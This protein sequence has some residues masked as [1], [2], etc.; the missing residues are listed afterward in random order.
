MLSNLAKTSDVPVFAVAG[1]GYRSAIH[2]L[3]VADGINIVASPRHA[4]V[5]LIAGEFTDSATE[6][7]RRVH[8]QMA[9]PR[10]TVSWGSTPTS[11]VPTATHVDGDVSTVATVIKKQFSDV[12]TGVIPAE[13]PVLGNV[14]PV[15]WRGVGPYGHGGAGMTGG[16]PYGRP[17]A[18]RA[19]S[20]DALEL[21]QLPVVIGPWF[22]G[23][24]PGLSLR[25]SLQGDVAQT[26][27]V[28]PTNPIGRPSNDIFDQALY[29]PV[30][31]RELEMARARHLIEWMADTFAIA[32]VDRLAVRAD[33]LAASISPG[34]SRP[35]ERLKAAARRA[36]LRP[37]AMRSA[38]GLP[39]DLDISM[40]GPTARASGV[41]SDRRTREQRYSEIDFH[42]VTRSRGDAWARF[43]QRADEAAQAVELAERAGDRRAFGNG[44]VEAPDGLRTTRGPSAAD[45]SISMLD[46]L[47]SGMEWGDLVTVVHSL[48][49]DMATVTATES[50]T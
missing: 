34:D 45:T 15:E 8:D 22:A 18:L 9:G 28:V 12:V 36:L 24:P 17:L 5:L 48:D 46:S 21:D 41:S 11:I 6:S 43:E 30:G 4:A 32:G 42:V 26:I 50:V 37:M 13:P 47:L 31:I 33:R 25:I 2:R 1:G 35:I 40:L 29:E 3:R 38:G 19:P 23:Y 20:R 49:I 44:E 39:D 16:T 14:D 10:Q 27:E 7:V